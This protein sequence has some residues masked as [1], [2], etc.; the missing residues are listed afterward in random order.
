[1]KLVITSFLFC[2]FQIFTNER[3][4]I[5]MLKKVGEKRKVKKKKEKKTTTNIIQSLAIIGLTC[6]VGYGV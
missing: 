3:C 6:K 1:M 2:I 5:F 4:L